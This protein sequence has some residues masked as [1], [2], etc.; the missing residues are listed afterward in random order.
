MFTS[1]HISQR[2][3]QVLFVGIQMGD[4]ARRNWKRSS[5][6]I[7]E[8][9]QYNMEYIYKYIHLEKCE[10]YSIDR[11]RRATKKKYTWIRTKHTPKQNDEFKNLSKKWMKKSE[12]YSIHIMYLWFKTCTNKK[13][14]IHTRRPMIQNWW[15]FSSTLLPWHVQQLALEYSYRYL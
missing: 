11:M 4:E 10:K 15:F 12:Q 5:N 9:L 1:I 2:I 8:Y 3:F 6:R 14:N 7:R 13:K